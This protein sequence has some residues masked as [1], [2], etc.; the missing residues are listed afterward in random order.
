MSYD[1]DLRVGAEH[2][3]AN[4]V[5]FLSQ[6]DCV[7]FTAGAGDFARDAAATGRVRKN[8]VCTS[9]MLL[10]AKLAH[11]LGHLVDRILF[12]GEM[13]GLAFGFGIAEVRR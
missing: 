9:T 5:G 13:V 11:V 1:M 2:G 8:P 12:G 6:A 7:H 4:V 3:A 10:S